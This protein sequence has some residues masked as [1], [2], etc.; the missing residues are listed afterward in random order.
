[1]QKVIVLLC[2]MIISLSLYSFELDVDFREQDKQLHAGGSFLLC[3][4]GML[5]SQNNF[6]RY[7]LS[8]GLTFGIGW[9]KEMTDDR[10]NN[11]DIQADLIGIGSALVI[12]S[13]FRYVIFPALF[14]P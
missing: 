6:Q 11:L 14:P 1:M 2:V 7:I 5:A 8:P 9:A 12:D 13:V 3:Q 10:Y 4:T